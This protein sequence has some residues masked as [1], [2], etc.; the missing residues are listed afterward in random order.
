MLFLFL[1]FLSEQNLNDKENELK[2]TI[3][4]TEDKIQQIDLNFASPKK[5]D[6]KLFRENNAN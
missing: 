6:T 5:V 1:L 2:K 3:K 4:S